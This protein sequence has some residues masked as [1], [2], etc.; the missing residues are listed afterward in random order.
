MRQ[1][2]LNIR[3]WAVAMAAL[4]MPF[5]AQ[6]AAAQAPAQLPSYEEVAPGEPTLIDGVWRLRELNK[7]V[8]IENGHVIALEGWSHMIFWQVTKG[9]VT[10]TS[11]TQVDDG[12]FMAYDILL[13]REMRWRLQA[14]GS[15]R[16]AGTG[17]FAP[18]FSLE[19]LELAYPEN[20][21]QEVA[22]M[23][24]TAALPGPIGDPARPGPIDIDAGIGTAIQAS[25]DMC[26][27]VHGPDRQKQGGKVQ[28]WSCNSGANQ[29]FIYLEDDRLIVTGAGM[30][31]E[32]VGRG[33]GARIQVF[34]C[35]GNEAQQWQRRSAAMA[36]NTGPTAGII[37]NL[38]RYTF[39]HSSGACLE[40]HR[41][42]RS[43]NGGQIQLWDCEPSRGQNWA[44][45][46]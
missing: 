5:T 18:Q 7:Q 15:I 9:M 6:Q 44:M 41:A 14:D 39:V 35:D 13:Q 28:L 25:D 38:P 20:F 23:G 1:A 24:G 40:V 11:L 8:L 29:E 10:S 21:A 19:P 36:G 2:I 30:C 42:D 43:K 16:A 22:L 12:Q 31:L 26:L 37:A 4:L 27:D 32:A 17:F 46:E 34:G 45:V 33:K 3:V